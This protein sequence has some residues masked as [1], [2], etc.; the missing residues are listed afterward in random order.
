MRILPETTPLEG[1]GLCSSSSPPLKGN[2]QIKSQQKLKLFRVKKVS[3]ASVKK[4]ADQEAQ[5]DLHKLFAD[6]K[7]ELYVK[8]HKHFLARY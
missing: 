2:S 6:L 7:A 5:R 8:T 3:E 4:R 1:D